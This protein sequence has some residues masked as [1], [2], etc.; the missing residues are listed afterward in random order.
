[1]NVLHTDTNIGFPELSEASLEVEQS[2]QR[3]KDLVPIFVSRQ[4]SEISYT[5]KEAKKNKTAK[6]AAKAARKKN[7][8]AKKKA[9]KSKK[10]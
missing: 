8:P 4:V 5:V 7:R 3:I 2:R 10:K 1:M 6:N 9:K